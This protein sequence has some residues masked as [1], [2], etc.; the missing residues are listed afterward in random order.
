MG[1]KIFG[2]ISSKY[3]RSLFKRYGFF[4]FLGAVV[5][6][7]VDYTQ[8][9]IP[10]YT[11]NFIDSLKS[12]ILIKN[13]IMTFLYPIIFAAIFVILGRF[14]WRQFLMGNARKIE[15][16]ISNDVYNHL[17][18]LGA[19]YYSN[20]KT[21]EIMAYVTNDINAIRE[22]MGFSF[23]MVFDVIFLFIFTIN[24]MIQN[25]SL[26]LTLVAC[27]P[28][29]FIILVTT[30]LEAKIHANFTDRQKKFSLISDFIQ[31]DLSGINVIK[32]F[33]QEKNKINQFEK[34][35]NK[36]YES[37][38]K[39]A[40]TRALMDPLL[41]FI[42]GISLSISI[43]YGGYLAI[44]NIIT[45]GEFAAF[46]QYLGMLVWPMMA[47]GFALNILTM[48]SASLKRVE[49]VLN[50]DI[51]IKD[52][53]VD[54]N[55]KTLKGDIVFRNLNFKYQ[56][57]NTPILK[58]INLVIENNKTLGIVGK[59]GSGKTTLVN[60]LVKLYNVS[61]NTIEIANHDINSIP[62]KTLR[63]NISIV[64]QE[65]FLFSMNIF[66]NVSLKDQ[67]FSN[68]Q[69]IESCKVACVHN[70]ILEFTNGYETVVGERGDN[71]SGGQKQRISIARALIRNPEILILDDS[72]SAVDTKTEDTILKHLKEERKGKTNIIIAHR[73]STLK[74]ADKI[75][76][77][78]NGEIVES[79]SHEELMNLKENYYRLYQE[80][81]L[82]EMEESYE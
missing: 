24:K 18:R 12:G 45:V 49:S 3:A 8:T 62:L 37:N 76:V 77:L 29:I 20:H 69:V 47:V 33:T 58:N 61:N 15:R 36:Y 68:E 71:L 80:Q 28:L 7:I 41:D 14:L 59:T 1:E 51:E 55:I 65:N 32:S 23:V 52:V 56:D 26:K 42:I 57:S 17:Q 40:Q 5:L 48:G 4:Y 44:Y 21:G 78:D 34:V 11:G 60:L 70:D 72:L 31:E 9:L 27:I 63:S 16:D 46:I 79:G 19:N 75:V 39:L 6:I 67:R 25:I 38:L 82:E 43:G 74:H 35:N 30:F 81:L 2:I 50:E 53:N 66:D 10:I 54:N 22:A 73:I 13:N 64:S